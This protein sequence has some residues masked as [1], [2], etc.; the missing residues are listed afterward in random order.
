MKEIVVTVSSKGQ[1]VVPKEIC[2][3]LGIAQGDKITFA[4]D[5]EGQVTVKA[6]KSSPF[7]ALR[8][9]AGNLKMQLSW[10][11]I[12]QIAREDHLQIDNR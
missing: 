12:R 6:I 8:G 1:V 2:K 7:A 10:D 4:L 5:A 11:E 9:A 3:H